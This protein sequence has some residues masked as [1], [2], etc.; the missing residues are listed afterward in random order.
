MKPIITEFFPFCYILICGF[1]Y[2][3]TPVS[4]V[5]VIHGLPQ[6]EKKFGKLKK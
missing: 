1:K 2:R 3:Q 5:S 6:P 4:T